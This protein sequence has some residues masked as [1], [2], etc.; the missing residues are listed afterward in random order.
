VVDGGGRE[1][2]RWRRDA[3]GRG[4]RLH[5]LQVSAHHS[6]ARLVRLEDRNGAALVLTDG[7]GRRLF[8]LLDL[9]DG[10]LIQAIPHSL[11]STPPKHSLGHQDEGETKDP[12]DPP[13][14]PSRETVQWEGMLHRTG[15]KVPG[16]AE[17][18]EDAED[19]QAQSQAS[20]H[21][22]ILEGPEGSLQH[23]DLD[24][25]VPNHGLRR[26]QLVQTNIE[27]RAGPGSW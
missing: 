23:L 21:P 1:W 10:K 7:V 27:R 9:A 6:G 8:L 18:F 24:L 14:Q 2:R 11:S 16:Q 19:S 3:D 26:P 5:I 15:T 25:L 22:R 12:P 20:Y 13:Q 4:G 17:E